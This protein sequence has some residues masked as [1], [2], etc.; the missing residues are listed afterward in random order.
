MAPESTSAPAK[1][2]AP[3]SAPAAASVGAPSWATV[4]RKGKKKATATQKPAPAAKPPS[5]TNAPAPKKGITLREREL[6][7]KRDG[8]PLTPTAMELRDTINSALSSTYVQTVSL[9]GGNVTLTA[10]ET[11]KATSLNSKA[12]AFLHLI[13][14]ATTVHLDTPATQLLV[15]GLPTSH[16]LATIVTE[17]TTFNSGLALTQ[18]RRWLTSDESRAN[19]SASSIVITITG[20]KAPLFVGK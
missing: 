5:P 19:K 15:H 14:G 11:V 9:T 8:S 4:A 16:S 13:P 17:L 10:M 18:Q 20:P 1:Q 3:S 2:P 12:S 6:V 7:I